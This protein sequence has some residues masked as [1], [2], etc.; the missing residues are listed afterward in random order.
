[1]SSRWATQDCEH[2]TGRDLLQAGSMHCSSMSNIYNC[3]VGGKQMGSV[4]T[5][6]CTNP[7]NPLYCQDCEDP[8][9]LCAKVRALTSRASGEST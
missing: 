3:F 7:H 9:E 1:M 2:A 4:C 5:N 8:R 6:Q